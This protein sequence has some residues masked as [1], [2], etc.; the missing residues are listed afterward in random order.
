[1]VCFNRTVAVWTLSLF[2]AF[3]TCVSQSQ[4]Q[5]VPDNLATPDWGDYPLLMSQFGELCTMCEAYLRCIPD[6]SGATSERQETLYYFQTKTFW[7]Q[8]ATIWDYFARWFDP[9]TSEERPA[10]IYRVST[11]SSEDA[12]VPTL[13]YLSVADA[14]VEIDGTWV[15][16]NSGEWFTADDSKIGMC[17]RKGIGESMAAIAQIWPELAAEN[18]GGQ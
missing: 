9:V 1:M 3:S 8:V 2:M 7:G 12:V 15:D 13:T 10:T 6:S 14:K 17:S 5:S 16:R 18:T 11:P 4:A